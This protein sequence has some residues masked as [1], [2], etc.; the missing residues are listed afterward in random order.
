MNNAWES[1]TT[2]LQQFGARLEEQK[3]QLGGILM[4]QLDEFRWGGGGIC[5]GPWGGGGP[6]EWGGGLSFWSGGG[7]GGP[8][9]G[10]GAGV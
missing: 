10:G 4:K 6:G 8:V 9:R 3:T 7:G 1:F 5:R 2:Q